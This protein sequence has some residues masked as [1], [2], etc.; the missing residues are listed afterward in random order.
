MNKSFVLEEAVLALRCFFYV[1]FIKGEIGWYDVMYNFKLKA[2]QLVFY[3]DLKRKFV[4]VFDIWH[5]FTYNDFNNG[6]TKRLFCEY[7]TSFFTGGNDVD[8]GKRCIGF[9]THRAI[10]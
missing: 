5:L 3:S 4:D 10:T 6:R 7:L 2:S 8:I 9:T 1:H